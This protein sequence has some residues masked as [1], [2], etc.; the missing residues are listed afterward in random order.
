MSGSTSQVSLSPFNQL[1]QEPQRRPATSSG[2]VIDLTGPAPPRILH[3][4]T[5]P[6]QSIEIIEVNSDDDQGNHD[7]DDVQ[8]ISETP[9][10]GGSNNNRGESSTTGARSLHNIFMDP[11]PSD[12]MPHYPQPQ[13]TPESEHRRLSLAILRDLLAVE[14]R[15]QR[16][17]ERRDRSDF[18]NMFHNF[19][20]YS[21]RFDSTPRRRRSR[22]RSP[23]I[24]NDMYM[25]PGMRTSPTWDEMD[26]EPEPMEP[27]PSVPARP[28]HTK[29]LAGDVIVA[30][31]ICE[32]ELGH[33]GKDKTTLWVVTGC[34]HVV[35][36]D[37]VEV[38]FTTK[39]P[40]KPSK[41]RRQSI[42]KRAKAKDKG[43]GRWTG[44]IMDVDADAQEEQD[45]MQGGSNQGV[46]S[47]A[48]NAGFKLVKRATGTC[49][50]CNRKIRRA[51]MQQL[52]L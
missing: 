31:P 30:C 15:Q 21:R 16:Q 17:Q 9:G 3:P 32:K 1:L 18:A 4:S 48:V 27:K 28:G 14:T 45:T 37:C 7:D 22:M 52:Y 34:G 41:G 20:A 39:V 38:M 12:Y 24:W 42:S 49:P 51:V 36:E 40:I 46:S 33:K 19:F 8:F 44:T 2:S 47:D 50:S 13:R 23:P 6:S 10:D 43:K 25:G 35:C 26:P 11:Y 29:S 5:L